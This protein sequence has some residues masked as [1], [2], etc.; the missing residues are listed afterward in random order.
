M[1]KSLFLTTP[2]KGVADIGA[3]AEDN[4]PVVYYPTGGVGRKNPNLMYFFYSGNRE[5]RQRTRWLH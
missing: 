5:H 2:D 4:A 1:Q 3:G